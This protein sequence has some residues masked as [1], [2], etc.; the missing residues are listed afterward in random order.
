MYWLIFIS[1]IEVPA[2]WF[3]LVKMV[4]LDNIIPARY[5]NSKV[6]YDAH[7]SGYTFGVVVILFLLSTKMLKSD[8]I[9]FFYMIRQWNRRRAY[10]DTLRKFEKSPH[11]RILTPQEAISTKKNISET[12]LTRI[13]TKRNLV[14]QYITAGDLDKASAEYIEIMR[15]DDSQTM[16]RQQQL[17]IANHLMSR[18]EAQDAA[19]AYVLFKEKYPKYNYIE[20]IDLMLGILYS[21]YLNKPQKAIDHLNAALE[22]L[23]DKG[24]IEMCENEIKKALKRI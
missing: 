7:L 24:Q 1:T 4:L 12:D 3:I 11:S 17:D 23:S 9:D 14:S 22:G 18:G 19:N 21:R 15:I 20:Q 13:I 6:A 10:R 2:F 8:G 16:P 5:M